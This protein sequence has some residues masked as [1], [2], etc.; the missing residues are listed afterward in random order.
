MLATSKVVRESWRRYVKISKKVA[1]ILTFAYDIDTHLLVRFRSEIDLGRGPTQ[2]HQVVA[3]FGLG[4]VFTGPN[5]LSSCEPGKNLVRSDDI[6]KKD[7]KT[8]LV[9]YPPKHTKRARRIANVGPISPDHIHGIPG[10]PAIGPDARLDTLRSDN[11]WPRFGVRHLAVI[12]D[13]GGLQLVC[14]CTVLSSGVISNRE[15]D[16][17]FLDTWWG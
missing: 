7:A 9:R 6:H 13:L 4:E 15:V 10:R 16:R 14:F 11:I 1:V 17:S 3:N 5:W 8:P 2:S 12:G